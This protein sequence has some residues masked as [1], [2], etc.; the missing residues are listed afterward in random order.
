MTGIFG[1]VALMYD[2]VRPGYPD[3]V[4]DAIAGHHGGTPRSVVEL[5]AGTGKGTELLVR[6]GAPV[7]CVEPDPRMAAVLRAKFPQAEVVTTTFEEWTPP[8]G[9]VDLIGCALAW[10][11]LDPETRNRRAHDALAPGGSLAVFG[12]RYWYAD[13]SQADRIGEVLSAV[14]PTVSD[15]GDH[16]IRDDVS[17]SG[18]WSDVEEHVWHNYPVFGKEKYLQLMQTF[19]PFRRRSPQDQAAALDGIGKV[20]DDVGGTITLDLIT[21]LVLARR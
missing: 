21:T 7:T 10:H 17:G 11:W 20:L 3:Q 19:S 8:P 16:W 5:G 15:R 2:D 6:L 4:L 18:V 1:T 9:G 12:H 13:Q 14:D